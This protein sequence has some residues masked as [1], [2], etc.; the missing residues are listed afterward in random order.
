[1][2]VDRGEKTLRHR[3]VFRLRSRLLT[4]RRFPQRSASS[5]AHSSPSL[6]PGAIGCILLHRKRVPGLSQH[7]AQADEHDR[8]SIG[9]AST[10]PPHQENCY[11]SENPNWLVDRS[12]LNG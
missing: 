6:Q 7:A 11:A 2:P 1:V 10:P 4:L 5:A 3:W 12:R 9:S 8:W